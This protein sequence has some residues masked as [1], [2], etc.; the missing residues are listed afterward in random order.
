MGP[1]EGPTALM[2]TYSATSE[3]MSDLG[4][5]KSGGKPAL[6]DNECD[7]FVA[8]TEIGVFLEF[9]ELLE[10][11]PGDFVGDA[12]VFS[13]AI[14]AYLTAILQLAQLAADRKSEHA[15]DSA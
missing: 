1:W 7:S 13:G 15:A 6:K 9:R 5:D 2:W 14:G 12:P 4:R 10:D 11:V 3:V 8:A